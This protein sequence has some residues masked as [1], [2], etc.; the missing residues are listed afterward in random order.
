MTIEFPYKIQSR[1]LNKERHSRYYYPIVPAI[2]EIPE[3][4]V[5]SAPFTENFLIDSGAAISILHQRNKRFFESATPFDTTNIIFGNSEVK[6]NVY[7]I[8]LKIEGTK[9]GISV[10]LAKN[11]KINYSLLGYFQG[12]EAFDHFVMNNK[13]RVFKLVKI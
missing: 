7:K 12:I 8:K 10:A 6:L 1:I 5:S 11:M 2:I 9:I 3:I 4:N 13:K